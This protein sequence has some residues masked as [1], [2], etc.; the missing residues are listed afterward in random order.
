[1]KTFLLALMMMLTTFVPA[2]AA[3]TGHA[4]DGGLAETCRSAVCVHDEQ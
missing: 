3:D 4:H 2:M 1:M